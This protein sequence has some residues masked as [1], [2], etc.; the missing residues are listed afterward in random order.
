MTVSE[1]QFELDGTVPGIRLHEVMTPSAVGA[2]EN[3]CTILEKVLSC[4]VGTTHRLMNR[5]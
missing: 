5:K 2:G 1:L 4:R 3:L